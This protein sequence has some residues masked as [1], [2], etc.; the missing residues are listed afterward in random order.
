MNNSNNIFKNKI[1]WRVYIAWFFKRIL[2]L[3]ALEAA[4]A[5]A[6]LYFVG[7]FIFVQQVVSNA[8]LNAASN[9]L[10][11]TQFL[12]YAFLKTHW[13][14]QLAIIAVFGLGAL[15]LRDLGRAVASYY[16]TSRATKLHSK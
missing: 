1:I 7:K 2:P 12:F 14:T 6:V 9:P 10:L 11:F 8:F 3:L 4:V 16:S 13:F 5:V 15:S